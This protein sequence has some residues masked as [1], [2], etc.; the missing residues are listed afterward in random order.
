M[1]KNAVQEARESVPVAIGLDRKEREKLAELL[2][3]ALSDTYVLYTKV[4]GVHWNVRGPLFYSVHKM[5]EQQYE[6]L[7]E[8]IDEIA[9]RVRALGFYAPT[10]LGQML[11]ASRV[12]RRRS[13]SPNAVPS[14]PSAAAAGAP[15]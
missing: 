1:A 9:E 12:T 7:A 5:T 15:P 11:E 4:Q 13:G 6:D 10:S 8:S 3:Q 14:R 2:N